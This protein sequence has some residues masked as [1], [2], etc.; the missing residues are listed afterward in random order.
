MRGRGG[1][2]RSI[3]EDDEGGWSAD[4]EASCWG[5][6]RIGQGKKGSIVV[7]N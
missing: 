3:R 7:C 1:G 5:G 6:K 4:D 2:E